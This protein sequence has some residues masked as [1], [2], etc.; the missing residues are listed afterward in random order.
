M[1]GGGKSDRPILPRKRGN[2]RGGKGPTDQRIAEPRMAGT[3]RPTS[4]SLWSLATRPFGVSWFEEPC[5]GNP[6]ARF[7]GGAP[8]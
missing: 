7:R 3:Q 8:G 6:H 4:M 1:S 2:A 5:A